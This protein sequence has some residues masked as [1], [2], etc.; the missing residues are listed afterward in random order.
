MLIILISFQKN[1]EASGLFF[2]GVNHFLEEGDD[3]EMLRT[4]FFALSTL[5]ADGGFGSSGT[6]TVIVACFSKVVEALVFVHH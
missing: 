1:Y 2:E 5:D 3:R 4:G 6:P